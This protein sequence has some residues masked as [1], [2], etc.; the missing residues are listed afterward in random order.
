VLGIR[1]EDVVYENNSE[2]R[3]LNLPLLNDSYDKVAVIVA[4]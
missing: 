2:A 3:N 1:G 4:G